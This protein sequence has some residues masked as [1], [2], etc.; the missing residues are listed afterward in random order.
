[1]TPHSKHSQRNEITSNSLRQIGDQ[2]S[3]KSYASSSIR[4]T[5]TTKERLADIER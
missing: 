1:M 3:R 2:I 4:T 5:T